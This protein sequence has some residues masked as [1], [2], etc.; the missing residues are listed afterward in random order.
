[1][2]GRRV[3]KRKFILLALLVF[4]SFLFQ[5]RW[6]LRAQ[7]AGSVL[8]NLAASMQPGSFALLNQDGD[9]S[10]YNANLIDG[11]DPATGMGVGSIYGYAQKA[12]YD[13]VADRVYF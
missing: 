2:E 4:F 7:G 8:A 13:P 9:G 10:G 11:K 6:N 1:M 5:E 3:T 12:A